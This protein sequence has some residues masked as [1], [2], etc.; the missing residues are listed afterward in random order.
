MCIDAPVELL[1]QYPKHDIYILRHII[2][3]KEARRISNFTFLIQ[4]IFIQYVYIR[5]KLFTLNWINC[6]NFSRGLNRALESKMQIKYIKKLQNTN[7]CTIKKTT[8]LNLLL[9][10][11]WSKTMQVIF[12][13]Y[14]YSQWIISDK[15]HEAK[16]HLLIF[17]ETIF[18]TRDNMVL[19]YSKLYLCAHFNI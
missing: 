5:I 16:L 9:Q 4:K 15:I 2:P 10:G 1:S 18:T 11:S 17:S 3:W 7:T 14:N 13:S 12:R 8:E 6:Y 19:F